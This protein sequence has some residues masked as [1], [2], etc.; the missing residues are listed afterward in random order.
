MICLIIIIYYYY[1][2]RY[3][4]HR[5]DVK[6]LTSISLGVIW[7]KKWFSDTKS[8]YRVGT[9]SKFWL[10][11]RP[12]LI[13]LTSLCP[14]NQTIIELSTTQTH[15]RFDGTSINL[16]QHWVWPTDLRHEPKLLTQWPVSSTEL[17]SHGSSSR[18]K[19]KDLFHLERI[20]KSRTTEEKLLKWCTRSY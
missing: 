1:Y 17:Y 2:Y 19:R 6:G 8:L 14:G 16:L 3:G 13:Q 18:R 10:M 11:I 9:G 5:A 7:W 15:C 12:D 20:Q 4:Q